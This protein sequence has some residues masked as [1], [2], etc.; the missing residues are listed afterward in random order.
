[1]RLYFKS[2]ALH[3]KS[4]L[5]YKASFIIA[6]L[7]QI[8]VV[9]SY[10]FII[11]ALFEQFGN[12]KGFTLYEVLLCFGIIQFGFSFCEV[13]ARG[14]DT[15]DKLIVKGDFDRLLLRPRN[16]ILQILCSDADFVKASRLL[17]AIIVI[18]IIIIVLIST[19]FFPCSI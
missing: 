9:F 4:L 10:Y 13:F 18:I 8:L 16:I 15:F 6:F 1:M 17:Q 19:F 7:C 5:E 3:F 14:M 2:F 12:V 11:L